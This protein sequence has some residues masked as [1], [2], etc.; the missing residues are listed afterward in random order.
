MVTFCAHSQLLQFDQAPSPPTLQVVAIL[1]AMAPKILVLATWFVK[2]AF[3]TQKSW[4]PNGDQAKTLT[5]RVANTHYFIGDRF[6]H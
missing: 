3:L 4:L 2:K 1:V 6:K 5:W